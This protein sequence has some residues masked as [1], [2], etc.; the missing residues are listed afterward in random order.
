VIVVIIYVVLNLYVCGTF[1]GYAV[2]DEESSTV[3]DNVEAAKVD[4]DVDTASVTE[5]ELLLQTPET[6]EKAEE[7]GTEFLL[8]AAD[9]EESVEPETAASSAIGTTRRRKS[10]VD[11]KSDRLDKN[12]PG[13]EM[14]DITADAMSIQPTGYTLETAHVRFNSVCITLYVCCDFAFFLPS[15]TLFHL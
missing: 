9:R 7:I 4:D 12:G 15:C 6:V 13:R 11:A 10:Q 3:A 5:T 2:D 1:C 14:N 8:Q